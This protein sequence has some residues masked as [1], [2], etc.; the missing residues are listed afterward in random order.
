MH[1]IGR[2]DASHRLLGDVDYWTRAAVAGLR[3]CRIDDVLALMVLHPGALSV[4]FPDELRRELTTIRASVD[5]DTH[6][7]LARA[8][9]KLRNSA[10]WRWSQFAF[11]RESRR[12]SPRRWQRFIR[13]LRDLGVEVRGGGVLPLLVPARFL[14]DGR[15]YQILDAEEFERKLLRYLHVRTK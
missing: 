12:R 14:R 1:Y 10:T 11:R 13:F 7:P 6:R 5:P 8:T 9:V 2:F 3:F 15:L 4:R